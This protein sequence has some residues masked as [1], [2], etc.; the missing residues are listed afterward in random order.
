MALASV[1]QCLVFTY[2]YCSHLP[3]F[4]GHL[5]TSPPG[6]PRSL[7]CTFILE[8]A[9][10]V[11]TENQEV[12]LRGGLGNQKFG[13]HICVEPKTMMMAMSVFTPTPPNQI[14][15][16]IFAPTPLHKKIAHC[17]YRN[18]PHTH[19]RKKESSQFPPHP[20]N[21]Q[22][23]FCV[24]TP[25]SPNI[26]FFEKFTPEPTTFAP[27]KRKFV[28]R[29]HL[30]KDQKTK[31]FSLKQG[32]D[33]VCTPQCISYSLVQTLSDNNHVQRPPGNPHQA[34]THAR[35]EC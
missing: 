13:F 19:S 23:F 16:A 35:Q 10:H 12:S 28:H 14:F 1:S 3:S 32:I 11:K 4:W 33:K 34:T 21:P 9:R 29:T 22:N 24:F 6:H 8:M 25:T 5:P 26:F 31:G 15:F 17:F 30:A 18:T 20:H 2:L 27:Q 7:L